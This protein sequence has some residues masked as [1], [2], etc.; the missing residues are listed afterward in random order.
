M[1]KGPTDPASPGQPRYRQIAGLLRSRISSGKLKPGDSL[2]TEMELC[3]TFD[4]SRHTA[5]DALRLLSEDG[6]IERRRGAGT[7]V[8]TPGPAAFAQAISDFDSI[9]QYA[10]ETHFEVTVTRDADTDSI[11]RLGLTGRYRQFIGFRRTGNEPPQAITAIY[12]KRNLAPDA[13]TITGL[14][15]SISEWIETNHGIS[16]DRVLQRME[17]VALNASQA[18]RLGVETGFAALRTVRRYQDA[19]GDEVLVSE[20]LHPA[21]RFAYEM[22][23]ERKR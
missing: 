11:S 8:T 20:S 10:R 2:P 5:R 21:G 7:I 19:A 4:I 18:K 9:L 1:T 13:A 23:L 14:S 17:A 15:G 22:Q 16:I 12:V 6:L 3:E